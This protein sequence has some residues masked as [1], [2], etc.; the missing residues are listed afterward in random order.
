[1]RILTSTIIKL[2]FIGNAEDLLVFL[3]KQKENNNKVPQSE[4]NQ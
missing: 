2:K 1:M 4:H 3:K